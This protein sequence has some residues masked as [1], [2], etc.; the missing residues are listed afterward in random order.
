MVWAVKA[1]SYLDI[2]YPEK[3]CKHETYI[4]Q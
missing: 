4:N 2:M 3:L 1:V